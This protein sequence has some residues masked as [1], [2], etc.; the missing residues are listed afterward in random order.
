MNPTRPLHLPAGFL[1]A[2]GL[3]ARRLL[4]RRQSNAFGSSI[5]GDTAKIGGL[6]VI[7]LD[8][9][10]DRWQRITGELSLLLDGSRV[11]LAKRAIR[12]SACDAGSLGMALT[13]GVDV[14]P[15][16]TLRDQLFVEPQPHALPDRMELDHP[17]RM[18][19]PEIAIALSHIA[20]WRRIAQ[21][22]HA[23][24]LVLEDD[25]LFGHGF[26]HDLDR[27]WVEIQSTTLHSEPFDLLYLSYCEVKGGAPKI[28]ES[29]YLF[30]P[31]R[32]LW[33]LSGYVLSR[34]GAQKL[35]T[36]LPCR[37]PVDLWINQQFS[38]INV[39]ATRRSIIN[40]RRDCS[41]TNSYSV[42]PV[43]TKIGVLEG[44]SDSL[45]RIRPQHMPVFG[46]GPPGSGLSS[47]AMALSM[48]G[49]RCCSDIE[50]LPEPELQSLL[51]GQPD[52]VFDAYVNVGSLKGR[53][54]ALRRRYPQAK[55]ILTS[56]PAASTIGADSEALQ[57]LCGDRTVELSADTP[58]KWKII[59]EHLGCSPPISGFPDLDEMGQRKL[60]VS[61]EK[62]PVA[63]GRQPKRDKSPW[64]VGARNGWAGIRVASSQGYLSAP[65]RH[66]FTDYFER[67]DTER[68][69]LRSDTFPANLALFRPSNIEQ[70]PTAGLV[71]TVKN[72]QLGVREFSA[73]S[74]SSQE[75]FLYGRFEAVLR[76]TKVPGIV[77]GF[78][79]HRDTPR[80]EIDV[81]FTGN[82]PDWLLANVFYNPGGEGA[83]FDYGYRGA[84]SRIKLPFDASAMPHRYAIEWEPNILRWLVD[85][86]VVH[87]RAIWN[88]TPIPHLP[89][90]LHFNSWPSRSAELAGRLDRQRLPAT[91]S[92]R[93]VEISADAGRVRRLRR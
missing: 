74:I 37:G 43:L 75:R 20:V 67:L 39:L 77:T 91:A 78:F 64:I 93:A 84:P 24:A 69:F 46:F 81:E 14:E 41:S 53:V 56:R 45:F 2:L 47:L 36:L 29:Q 1:Y 7:N 55:F 50:E 34:R 30:R 48:L 18:S 88:P 8:R 5:D 59:C 21:G 87:E 57:R 16:Y 27:T 19:Q 11:A 60:L 3:R 89:M 70:C 92:I 15:F 58:D 62:R 52:R 80:Q 54:A 12:H 73:G 61:D 44:G 68:W 49:Y 23:N 22:D 6:Y 76:A 71:I 26:A 4:P 51:F 79:L 85:G 10:T 25:V 72:E 65:R 82:H 28:F 38:K 35:L 83:N 86:Q 32:G 40:Q 42:L 90:T 9:Q 63:V 31:F 33:C 17:I 66:M 13:L